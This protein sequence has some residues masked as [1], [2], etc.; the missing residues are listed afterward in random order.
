MWFFRLDNAD[1]FL[2]FWK[3][4]HI[5]DPKAFSMVVVISTY[6]ILPFWYH[7]SILHLKLLNLKDENDLFKLSAITQTG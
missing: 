3:E 4:R 5:Y 6:I 2:C 1:S 7:Q